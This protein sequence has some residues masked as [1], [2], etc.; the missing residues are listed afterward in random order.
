MGLKTVRHSEHTHR[1]T[2]THPDTHG[3]THRH[4][5]THTHRHIL[6]ENY[7]GRKKISSF[8]G[9]GQDRMSEG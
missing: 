7:G 8:K 4:T 9:W 6:R 1:E 2:H 3:Q 5:H